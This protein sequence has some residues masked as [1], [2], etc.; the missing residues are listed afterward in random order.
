M[1]GSIDM[2]GVTVARRLGARRHAVHHHR[3]LREV[4]QRRH[5]DAGAARRAGALR[6]HAR[7]VRSRPA[8]R[9]R[10]AR[11]E[12]GPGAADRPVVGQHVRQPA[13]RTGSFDDAAADDRHVPDHRQRRAAHSAAHHQVDHRRRTAPAPTSRGPTAS[14]WCRR[15]PR[16]RCGT[17]CAPP[18]RRDPT[19]DAAGHRVRRRAVEGYQIAGKTG[20]A[21]QINPGC[22]CYYDDVY[23]ITFAGMVPPT[24]RATSSAS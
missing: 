15:R 4:V 14:G 11:R 19:G 22:G 13:Y 24:T 2:G 6:R 9:R 8:H 23:W 20:T 16:R 10:A 21:Q 18:S 5:A 1:P 12:R 7:Q 3:R 17:C